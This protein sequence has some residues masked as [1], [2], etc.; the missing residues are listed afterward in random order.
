MKRNLL[1]LFLCIATVTTVFAVPCAVFADDASPAP[2]YLVAT[3]DLPVYAPGSANTDQADATRPVFSIPDTYYFTT[4][5]KEYTAG[6]D[7]F[8][9]ISYDGNVYFVKATDLATMSKASVASDQITDP[10][11]SQAV[12]GIALGDGAVTVYTAHPSVT[13]YNDPLTTS[14]ADCEIFDFYGLTNHNQTTYV[15]CHA[16]FKIRIGSLTAPLEGNLYIPVAS[17]NQPALTLDSVPACRHASLEVAPPPQPDDG[18]DI[19]TAPGNVSSDAQNDIVRNILIGVIVVLCVL[20]VFL[21]FKPSRR[22][23]SRDRSRD[24]TRYN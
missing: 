5:G 15:Y 11:Y 13:D 8:R 17:T 24:N 2:S 16:K 14:A 4:T 22:S 21:I 1:I 18:A 19:P 10:A 3:R 12:S 23:K 6:S 20:V 9:Q 7:T